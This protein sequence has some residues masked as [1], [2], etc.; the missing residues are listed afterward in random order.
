MYQLSRTLLSPLF[1]LTNTRRGLDPWAA[2]ARHLPS[3]SS[4][5]MQVGGSTDTLLGPVSQRLT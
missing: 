3:E 1:E 2:Y 4:L 5:V